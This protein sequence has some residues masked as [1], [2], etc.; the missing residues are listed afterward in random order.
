VL[1]SSQPSLDS[2]AIPDARDVRAWQADEP[3]G[4]RSA[5]KTT[6]NAAILDTIKGIGGM[7]TSHGNYFGV[8]DEIDVKGETDTPEFSIDLA[9]NAVPSRLP[10]TRSSTART[11]TRGSSASRPG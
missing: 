3:A 6:F 8:L 1:L 11:A 10:F 9:A 4:R 5:V 7:L 2:S